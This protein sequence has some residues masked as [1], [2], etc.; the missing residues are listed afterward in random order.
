M[1]IQIVEYVNDKFMALA[2]T[3][4]T[5]LAHA[6]QSGYD[7]SK[8]FD[9]AV[10]CFWRATQQQIYRELNKMEGRGWVN[11]QTIQQ[12]GKPNKKVYHLTT[13]GREELLRWFIEPS[14]PTPIRED[15][16]VKVLAGPYVDKTWLMS[17]LTHRLQVHRRQLDY[18]LE[19]EQWFQSQ[20][21]LPIG[22]R[23]RYLTLRR[24]IRHEQAWVEWCD[25]AIAF[26]QGDLS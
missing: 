6:P 25:E 2:H 12:E 8:E 3:I 4:L 21:N 23:F 16:L 22:D 19:K 26:V 13:E 20:Q 18:Y 10:S 11:Y 7:I 1:Y 9:E 14:E 15:L 5:V 17:E 24:G